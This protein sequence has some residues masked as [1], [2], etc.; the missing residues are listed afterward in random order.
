[1]P[2][3]PQPTVPLPTGANPPASGLPPP[4]PS[5]GGSQPGTWSQTPPTY[6]APGYQAPGYQAPGYQTPGYQAATDWQPSNQSPSGYAVRPA[7]TPPQPSAPS[8]LTAAPALAASMAITIGVAVLF[9]ADLF[10]AL[11]A[12]TGTPGRDRLL[13]FL[14]PA[15][16]AVGVAM[17]VAVALV[18]LHRQRSAVDAGTVAGPPGAQAGMVAML[19]GA[20]AALVGAAA[21]LRGI[22]DLTVPHQH[23]AI[24]VGHFIDALAAALVA[25]AAALWALRSRD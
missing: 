11:G 1:M 5:S 8:L 6:Q 25:A 12:A 23:G 15:D 18:W 10:I 3:P 7:A 16:L 20:V 13:E 21:L 2:L 24:K 17:I 22:V 4:P 14:S 9:L 19:A